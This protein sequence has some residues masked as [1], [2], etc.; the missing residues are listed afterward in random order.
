M[1][2]ADE[3]RAQRGCTAWGC[4]TDSDLTISIGE[5]VD[6]LWDEEPP[7]TAIDQVHRHVVNVTDDPV[8]HSERNEALARAIHR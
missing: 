3:R 7:S 6:S 2:I 5:L 4:G 8:A 1:V